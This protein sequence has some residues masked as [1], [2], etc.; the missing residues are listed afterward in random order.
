VVAAGVEGSRYDG[1]VQLHPMHPIYLVG[2]DGSSAA[3]PLAWLDPQS[4]AF[5][6]KGY[7]RSEEGP[8]NE[9]GRAPLDREGFTYALFGGVGTYLS[10]DRTKDLGTATTIQFGYYPDQHWGV[11]ADLFLGWRT[12]T[13]NQVLFE[14]R[15]ALE[16]QV[17]PVHAGPLHFGLYGG[18]GL[19][20]R[21]EDGVD[22]SNSSGALLG[23]GQ[24]QL[25]F[26]TRLALTGRFGQTWA[27]GELMTDAMIGLAVY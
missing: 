6:E 24:I 21:F 23:G 5:A 4:A 19:A 13:S 11:V 22:G 10:A 20:H 14:N 7:I 8:W 25:D 15:Y 3:M 1:Y 27:H 9:L 26:N 2:R 18:L 12:N 17:Y 16:G